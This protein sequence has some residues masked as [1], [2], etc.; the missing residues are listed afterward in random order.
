MGHDSSTPPPGDSDC[1]KDGDDEDKHRKEYSGG[2]LRLLNHSNHHKG[3]SRYGRGCVST[4]H[5]PI[6][7]LPYF[8]GHKQ[9]FEAWWEAMTEGFTTMGYQES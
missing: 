6:I 4:F 2:Y 5:P 7:S 8:R 1:N 9:S 3:F